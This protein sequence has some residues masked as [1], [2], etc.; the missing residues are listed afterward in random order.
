M[1]T[2]LHTF[3]EFIN[4][5]SAIVPALIYHVRQSYLEAKMG[6]QFHIQGYYNIITVIIRA[7]AINELTPGDILTERMISESQ[8]Q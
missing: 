8:A 3:N 7:I 5:N 2:S 1:H 4:V 6:K